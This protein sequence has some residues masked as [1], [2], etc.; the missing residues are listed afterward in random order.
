MAEVSQSVAQLFARSRGQSLA[1]S[2]EEKHHEETV[3]LYSDLM[4][5]TYDKAASYLNVVTLGG[6][7]AFF[8]LWSLLGSDI[9]TREKFWAG[10]LIGVSVLLF[11]GF[12]VAKAAILHW[13]ILKM[14]RVASANPST[15]QER[16]SALSAAQTA[17]SRIAVSIWLLV[18]PTCVL[19]GV[20]GAS[21]LLWA[22][23]TK[24][25]SSP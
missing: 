14:S 7:A 17:T 2:T 25:F 9:S 10:L 24:L 13:Q 8:A 23:A 5:V 15:L 19:T 3:K 22:F 21:I 11:V 12:E 4:T 6:Y 16:V 18:F 20:A 1:I